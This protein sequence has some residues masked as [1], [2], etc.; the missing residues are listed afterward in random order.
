MSRITL[1]HGTDSKN[2][3]AGLQAGASWT[4]DLRA[5]SHYAMA[6]RAQDNGG[7]VRILSTVIDTADLA[8]IEFGEIGS[9]ADRLDAVDASGKSWGG[10]EGDVDISPENREHD[11]FVVG[12]RGLNPADVWVDHFE[13]DRHWAEL[14]ARAT[15]DVA[16]DVAAVEA[17]LDDA[18]G[19]PD[20]D[21]RTKLAL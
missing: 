17:W 19:A 11:C 15:N 18:D 16:S 12:P 5:A 7:I 10:C 20:L 1:Y 14:N 9:D 4:Q 2:P 13:L 8:I 21:I 6:G 3:L